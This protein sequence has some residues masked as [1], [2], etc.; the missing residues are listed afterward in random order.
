M[1]RFVLYG[2]LIVGV[3]S[4]QACQRN[5]EAKQENAIKAQRLQTAAMYNTE[6]G[7]AYLK[8][9]NRPRAKQKLLTALRLAPKSPEANA[10]MGYFLEKTGS[11]GEARKFYQK[12]L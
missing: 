8:Q 5:F 9:G 2:L 11:L 1:L 4:I 12:A 7:I 10:A 6:L 3:L